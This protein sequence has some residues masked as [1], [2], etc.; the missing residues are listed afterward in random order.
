MSLEHPCE[1]I[2]FYSYTG[3]VGR[4]MALANVA[5]LLARR[6]KPERGVLMVDWD[7]ES[8]SLHHYFHDKCAA[9]S[10]GGNDLNRQPGLLDLFTKLDSLIPQ[11]GFTSADAAGV[12]KSLDPAEFVVPTDVPSLALMKA[13]RF[14]GDYFSAVTAFPWASLHGRA[15]WLIDALLDDWAARYR[16]VLIDCASGVNDMS[17]LCAMALPDKLLAFF[18]PNRQSLLG[19]LDVARCAA[20]YRKNSGGSRPL[21]IF[22][23]PSKIEPA[24]PALRH[25]WRFGGGSGEL[26]GYQARFEGLF[27][28]VAPE[29][30]RALDAYFDEIQIPYVPRYCYGGVVAASTPGL[31]GSPLVRAYRGLTERLVGTKQPWESFHPGEDL[32]VI[33]IDGRRMPLVEAQELCLDEIQRRVAGLDHLR[34]ATSLQVLASIKERLGKPAEAEAH[35]LEAVALCRAKH[36]DAGVAEA[37]SGLAR[38]ERLLGRYPEARMYYLDASKIYRNNQSSAALAATLAT[39]GD[40]D[41]QLGEYQAAEEHYC[42]AIERFQGEWDD[43]GVAG[44]YMSLGDLEKRLGRA[45]AALEHYRQAAQI[46]HKERDSLGLA[47]ALTSVGE[48]QGRLGKGESSEESYSRAVELY[49]GRHDGTRLAAALRSLADVRRGLKKIDLAL[50]HYQEAVDL[51]RSEGETLGLASALQS[52]ADLESRAGK[53]SGSQRHYEEAIVLYRTGE[54]NL[55]VANT[56]RSLGDLERRLNRPEAARSNYEQAMELYRTEANNIG[57]ANS[58]QSLGDL[59]KRMGKTKEAEQRYTQAIQIYR[60][61]GAS[62]G[63]ANSLKSLGDVETGEGNLGVA[64]DHYLQAI[65][66]YRAAGRTLGLANALQSLGDLE[67]G[68]KRFKEATAHYSTARDM[69]R[70]EKHLTGLAYTCSELARVS[71]ALFDFTGSIEYLNEASIA[72]AESNSPSVIEYVWSVQREIRGNPAGAGK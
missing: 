66:L 23:V 47:R 60:G 26:E 30:D 63:L 21:A 24:E 49:R 12:F 42:E 48:M 61:E 29:S 20:D 64:Q 37:V 39:L 10:A 52:L 54:N 18:T 69:Y 59:E 13:G 1:V 45:E 57:L 41:F 62:L 28:E 8:P 44:A 16:Y 72:A 50:A 43:A 11:S 70:R 7:L 58:L 17:G 19:V 46:L 32:S 22:P 4:S 36:D 5:C 40:L 65:E 51:F 27:R 38:L 3:G 9:W 35:Y 25:D 67:R 14:D 53:Q 71:H 34:A 56:M 33:E 55:G 6:C 15:P 68:Q 31:S 2:T